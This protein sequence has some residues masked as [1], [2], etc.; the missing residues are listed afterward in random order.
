MEGKRAAQR[1]CKHRTIQFFRFSDCSIAYSLS[2]AFSYAEK[3]KRENSYGGRGKVVGLAWLGLAWRRGGGQAPKGDEPAMPL[4][5]RLFTLCVP[6]GI[7][8]VTL[9]SERLMLY[10]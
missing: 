4:L 10:H 3:F 8:P 5:A 7:E 9:S 2:P 1:V 6:T